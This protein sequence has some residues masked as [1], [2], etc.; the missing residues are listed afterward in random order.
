VAGLG[1][2]AESTALVRVI[3]GLAETFG[4]RTIAEGVETE[5]QR[6]LLRALGCTTGQGYLFAR[7]LPADELEALLVGPARGVGADRIRADDEELAA[8]EI[9]EPAPEP[10]LAIAAPEQSAEAAD[11]PAAPGVGPARLRLLPDPPESE[12]R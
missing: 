8:A 9:P 1:T 5:S 6:A 12:R 3:M 4:L 10:P 11:E 7:P 2:N